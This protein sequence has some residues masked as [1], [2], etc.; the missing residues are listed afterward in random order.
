MTVPRIENT[1]PTE[2]AARARPL[3][4]VSAHTLAELLDVSETTIWDWTRKGSLPRPKKI[5]GSTR[6][7]WSEVEATLE[8][9]ADCTD[10]DPILR[11]SRGR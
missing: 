7:K 2:V 3:A 5:A 6:W 8:G 1:K 10:D 9:S 11:A 4:Y